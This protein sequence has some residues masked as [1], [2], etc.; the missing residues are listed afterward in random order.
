MRN[1]I[2]IG[3]GKGGV[4][5]TTVAVNFAVALARYGGRVGLIDGDVYGPNIPI[6]LG[7]KAQ[8]ESSGKKIVPVEKY[9]IRCVSMGFLT[10]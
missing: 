6:M 5:K 4:G 1:V 9:G 3:A 8:L 2:A 7:L 10:T